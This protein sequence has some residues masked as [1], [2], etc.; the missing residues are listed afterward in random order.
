MSKL[1]EFITHDMRQPKLFP[2]VPVKK[3]IP[4]WFKN[5]PVDLCPLDA[6]KLAESGDDTNKTIK[7]CVPV[8]DYLTSGYVL[9]NPNDIVISTERVVDSREEHPKLYE[10]FFF[11]SSQEYSP[12]SHSNDQCPMAVDG[13]LKRYIKLT[14]PWRIKTPPGYSCLFYQPEFF[15]EDRFKLFPGVVDTDEYPEIVNFPGFITE[16]ETFVIEAGTPLVVVFPFKRD[17]WEHE[18]KVEPLPVDN[19]MRAFMFQAY[20]RIFHKPKSYK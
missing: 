18:I 1:I 5:I 2:P 9:R 10:E 3:C 6:K 13:V 16:K 8:Q 7:A 17:E 4:E 15:M 20:K 19:P 11:Y 14:H 12:G